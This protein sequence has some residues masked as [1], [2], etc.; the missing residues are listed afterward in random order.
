[1][2]PFLL[3]LAISLASIALMA[4]ILDHL[5]IIP[6]KGSFFWENL[7]FLGT[8][9]AVLFMYVYRSGTDSFVQIYLLTM[10]VKLLAYG[11][12]MSFVILTDKAGAFANVVS[13]L[14]AYLVFT[15]LEIIFL[16]RRTRV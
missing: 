10:V 7:I 15:L 8:T 4:S 5:A 3:V 1:L 14:S 11:G 16:Y 9:T 13:F 12:Y 2:K 6:S